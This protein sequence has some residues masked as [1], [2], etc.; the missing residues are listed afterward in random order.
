MTADPVN[1]SALINFGYCR[2]NKN[3]TFTVSLFLTLLNGQN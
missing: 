3:K 2:A 1:P